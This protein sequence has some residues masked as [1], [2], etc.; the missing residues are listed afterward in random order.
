MPLAVVFVALKHECVHLSSE[1]LI[2]QAAPILHLGKAQPRAWFAASSAS[3]AKL[4]ASPTHTHS[5]KEE[6]VQEIQVALPPDL[7]QL[8]L[9]LQLSLP[10]LDYLVCPREVV[11][12][13]SCEFWVPRHSNPQECHRPI[14]PPCG[15]QVDQDD[16]GP[17]C[18]RQ[19]SEPSTTCLQG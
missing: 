9:L 11:P 3:W 5:G 10:Q 17:G 1:V 2:R 7:L 4:Q 14:V 12:R 19:G 15:C 8:C 16:C 6:D 18:A 13:W